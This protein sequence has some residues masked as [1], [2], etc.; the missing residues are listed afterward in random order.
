MHNLIRKKR[1]LD[2]SYI[3]RS[4]ADSENI[5][6]SVISFC[7]DITYAVNVSVS[8]DTSLACMI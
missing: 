7:G 8:F 5:T 1:V 4:Y 2:T 3:I 6:C